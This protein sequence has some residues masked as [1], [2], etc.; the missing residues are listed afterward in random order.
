VD[1]GVIINNLPLFASGLGVT[2]YLSVITMAGSLFFGTLFAVARLEGPFGLRHLSGLYIELVRSTPL[3]MIIFWVFFTIPIVSGRHLSAMWAAGLSLTAFHTCYLAEVIRSGIVSI[4]RSQ[5]EAAMSS[6]LNYVQAMLYV[7][8]PQAIKRMLPAL[9][10]RAVSIV[11]ST[12]FVY[13][14]GI[15]DFFRI[16]T[17]V[18]NREFRP[19]EIYAFVALVYFV[20]CKGLGLLER[21]VGGRPAMAVQSE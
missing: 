2:L 19:F 4:P 6:G 7:V 10:R 14:I 8:L 15:S 3:I 13:L 21:Y 20:I 12:S 18:N 16:A 9:V 17:I 5:A 11:K 1:Y